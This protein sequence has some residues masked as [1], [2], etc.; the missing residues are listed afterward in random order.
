MIEHT[1]TPWKITVAEKES[2]FK[3]LEKDCMP[4]VTRLIAS[5]EFHDVVAYNEK[6]AEFIVRACNNHYRLLNICERILMG[7]NPDNIP[8][9]LLEDIRKVIDEVK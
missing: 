4:R 3:I 6:N 5:M 7:I 1:P 2:P 8:F 9:N